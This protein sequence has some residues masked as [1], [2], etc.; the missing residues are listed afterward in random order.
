MTFKRVVYG[1]LELMLS[2]CLAVVI[3]VVMVDAALTVEFIAL[4][5]VK[6]A[7]K[8]PVEVMATGGAEGSSS[9]LFVLFLI[10]TAVVA[11]LAMEL[12][13]RLG[14]IVLVVEYTDGASLFKFFVVNLSFVGS[15]VE[16]TLAVEADVTLVEALM[17]LVAADTF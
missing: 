1:V 13:A 14:C 4:T 12:R 17:G 3:L 10:S 16:V 15:L 9:L 6:S 2:E 5:V 8:C 11:L 7:L